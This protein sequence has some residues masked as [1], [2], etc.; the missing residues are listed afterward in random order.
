MTAIVLDTETTGLN[1]ATSRVIEIA[2]VDFNSGAV[3]LKTYFDPEC[4]I[5]E[6]IT[7]ITGITD[8]MVAGAPK[9]AD[10]A[11]DLRKLIEEAEV[12]IGYNPNFDKGMIDSEYA[13]IS[14]NNPPVLWPQLV[15]PKRLWDV[16]EPRE[17]RH[18]QNAYKRFVDQKGFEGAHGAL[19]DTNATRDV[20]M[21]QLH[22]FDLGK[23]A[24]GDMDPERKNWFGASHHI[25][26]T[27]NDYAVSGL[28]GDKRL[29]VNFGKHKGLPVIEVDSGFWRWVSERDFPDHVIMMAIKML[30]F[31]SQPKSELHKN[32]HTW[33]REYGV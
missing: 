30:D 11:A 19:A 14:D 28:P 4:P 7:K 24:W 6:E 8:E 26:W 23:V 31:S 16:Y 9:F 12:V 29:M 21:M 13:R 17:S 18:L 20:L 2:V 5:P 10:F 3:L 15:D 22:T 32:L 1:P 25:L 27:E 33:A